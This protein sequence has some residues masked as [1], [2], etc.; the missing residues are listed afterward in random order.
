M[1]RHSDRDGVFQL[2]IV[3]ND[4]TP[5][6]WRRILVPHNYTFF[7][8]HVAIQNAL[9]W[10]DSHLHAF[11]IAQKGTAIPLSIEFPNPEEDDLS[12]PGEQEKLDERKE[13]IA[14]YLG[15]RVKQCI[16][17]YDFGDGWTHSILFERELPADR[18]L[19]Y[20]Q[21]V[22][23]ENACPPEDCGGVGGYDYLQKVLKNPH[24]KEHKNMLEWLDIENPEEFNPGEFNCRDVEFENP[25]V[26]LAE[27]ERR[28]GL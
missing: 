17:D 26:C 1:K 23:G 13:K 9:G 15:T 22:A 5:R 3:L 16:Y 21:C 12:W 4:S 24:H 25:A 19:Q 11:H 6:V 20:P 28:F 10:M 14:D 18:T 8:L 2:K 7:D 27:W